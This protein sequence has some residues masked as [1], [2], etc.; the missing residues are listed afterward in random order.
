M[1]ERVMYGEMSGRGVN[2]EWVSDHMNEVLTCEAPSA[3]RNPVVEPRHDPHYTYCRPTRTWAAAVL[4]HPRL[5]QHYNWSLT[6]VS[7]SLASHGQ[8]EVSINLPT[9]LHTLITTGGIWDFRKLGEIWNWPVIVC[10]SLFTFFKTLDVRLLCAETKMFVLN[11]VMKYI[12]LIY[13]CTIVAN[14]EWYS[15][16]TR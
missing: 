16:D 7:V 6:Q 14:L 10:C 11:I 8:E 12:Y 9:T 2:N 1:A 13:F 4:L 15:Y 5:H 3:S